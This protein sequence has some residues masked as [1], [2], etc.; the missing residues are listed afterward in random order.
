MLKKKPIPRPKISELTE[1]QQKRLLRVYIDNM[2]AKEKTIFLN[3]AIKKVYP[4]S[5]KKN[6]NKKR[7]RYFT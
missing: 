2:P 3:K 7:K 4:K 6:G 5:F 1:N